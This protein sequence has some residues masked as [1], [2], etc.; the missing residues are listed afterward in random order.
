GISYGR[1]RTPRDVYT[2]L[3]EMGVTH[4]VWTAGRSNGWDSLAGDIMFFNFVVNEAKNRKNVGEFIVA[5]MPPAAPSA[6][7]HD[8]VVFLGSNTMYKP[9]L[10]AVHDLTVPVFGPKSETYPEPTEKAPPAGTAP[11][12]LVAKTNILVLDEKCQ[13]PLSGFEL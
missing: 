13:K 1:Q 6:P 5:K 12:A 11:S 2:L 9:G 8:A 7:F 4:V 3:R 10:Y